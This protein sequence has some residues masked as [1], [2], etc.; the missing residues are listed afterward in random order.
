M[1]DANVATVTF[2]P[3]LPS[4][5]NLNSRPPSRKDYNARHGHQPRDVTMFFEYI[6]KKINLLFI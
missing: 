4:S 5:T 3:E 6:K 2:K 1:A